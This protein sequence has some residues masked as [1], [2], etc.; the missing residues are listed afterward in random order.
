MSQLNKYILFIG[1]IL[2]FIIGLVMIF[3]AEKHNPHNQFSENPIELFEIFYVWAAA[4]C[5]PFTLFLCLF[6]LMKFFNTP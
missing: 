2:G 1:I 5:F 6:E 4:V 3:I